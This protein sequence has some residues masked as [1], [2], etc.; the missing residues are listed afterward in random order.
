MITEGYLARHCQGRRGGRGPAIIDIAQDHLLYLLTSGGFFDLGVALKGG[1]AIRKFWA[2]NAGRFSTD[3]DFAGVDDESAELLVDMVDRAQVGQFRFS[4]T[5]ID[6]TRRMR[7]DISSPF[8]EADVPARLDLGRRSLW[9]GR[10]G[11]WL[12]PRRMAMVAMSIHQRYEFAVPELPTSAVEEII[13]EKLAR[14]RRDSLVRD[15]YDLVWFAS[16]AFDESLVRGLL[17]LK[18]WTDVVDDGL[19]EAPFDPEQVLR[20][21]HPNEFRP[22]AIGYLTTPVDIPGWIATV[23]ERYKFLHDLDSDE[24]RLARCSKA[25]DWGA[26]GPH[27]GLHV[28]RTLGVPPPRRRSGR[29]RRGRRRRRGGRPR[30]PYPR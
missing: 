13:A 28:P 29:R 17:V 4:L 21:R 10:R 3:L 8:G 30:H 9:L 14:L 20:S 19:G 15:L 26:L 25:D 6:G 22:E 11:L 16:R 7:L 5:P 24:Q 23:R 18:V 12:P 27:P 2:G 1:T